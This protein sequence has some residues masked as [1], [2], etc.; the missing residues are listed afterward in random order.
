[1]V[2]LLK[3]FEIQPTKLRF[4]E[5]TTNGSFLEDVTV[6]DAGRNRGHS[7]AEPRWAAVIMNTV[8]SSSS[9]S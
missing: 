8:R 3:P 5:T 7:C 1:M 4:G 2:R 6:C 9:I